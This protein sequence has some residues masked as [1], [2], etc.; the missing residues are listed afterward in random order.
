MQALVVM[1]SGVDG[2]RV[3]RRDRGYMLKGNRSICNCNFNCN[4][5]CKLL[6]IVAE[7]SSSSHRC[8][9]YGPVRGGFAQAEL[10]SSSFPRHDPAAGGSTTAS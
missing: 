6:F 10:N 3:G 2:T 4:C 7:G 9:W 5:C 1:D 8:A